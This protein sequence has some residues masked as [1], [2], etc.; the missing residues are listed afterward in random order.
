MEN[1]TSGMSDLML[2]KNYPE[3]IE[4]H[5]DDLTSVILDHITEALKSVDES[6]VNFIEIEGRLGKYSGVDPSFRTEAV[7]WASSK[8]KFTPGVS[9]KDLG[10]ITTFLQSNKLDIVR[11]IQFTDVKNSKGVRKRTLNGTSSIVK[12]VKLTTIDIYNPNC[13]YSYRISVSLE[14]PESSFSG[15]ITYKKSAR[16]VSYKHYN[17]LY[18][19][20]ISE[21]IPGLFSVEIEALNCRDTFYKHYKFFEKNKKSRLLELTKG[22]TGHL[23]ELAR[24]FPKK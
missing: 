10:I 4:N 5:V 3:S 23:R 24:L 20:E 13:V 19:C 11:D 7:L 6:H 15:P 18:D 21:G 1:I 17:L 2:K 14:L 22:L 16:R 8:K 12:K 9:E